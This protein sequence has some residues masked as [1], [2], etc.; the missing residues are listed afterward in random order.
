MAFENEYASRFSA[1]DDVL[2]KMTSS[3]LGA[4]RNAATLSRAPS[5]A[6]VASRA[7]RVHGA[8]DVGVV[9]RVEVGLGVD[10]DLR[11]LRAVGAVEVDQRHAV[12]LA[13]QDRE[14]LADR[15]DVEVMRQSPTTLAVSL[16]PNRA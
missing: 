6:C 4:L 16:T 5:N 7:E 13:G 11:L 3:R 8:G 10:D 12:H 14:V 1:S 15:L 9:L 2:V